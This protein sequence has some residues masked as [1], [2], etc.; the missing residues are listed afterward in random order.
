MD[1]ILVTGGAGYIGSHICVA[2]LEKGYDLIIIDSYINSSPI[3]V[4]RV[5]EICT[6]SQK[7]SINNNI[8][9]FKG[10]LRNEI[11]LKNIAKRQLCAD[12]E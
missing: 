4:K 10:D 7:Y 8:K 3:S 6:N 12:C 11:F 9:F 5:Y 1:R 2:L